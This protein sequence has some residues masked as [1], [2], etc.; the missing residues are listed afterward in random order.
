MIKKHKHIRFGQ[1]KQIEG[2]E[3]ET[4]SFVHSGIP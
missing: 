3:L 1:D 4:Y 2:Q